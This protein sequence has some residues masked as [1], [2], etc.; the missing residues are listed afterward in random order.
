[1]KFF[2]QCIWGRIL[3][4]RQRLT[5]IEVMQDQDCSPQ[6][7]WRW[8]TEHGRPCCSLRHTALN[9]WKRWQTLRRISRKS[10]ASGLM[11]MVSRPAHSSLA[12]NWRIECII[13]TDAT[14]EPMHPTDI[15]IK[16]WVTIFQ[17]RQTTMQGATPFHQTCGP[18]SLV[19]LEIIHLNIINLSTFAFVRL[20][21]SW[22]FQ[23]FW[24]ACL[25][26]FPDKY[27]VLGSYLN[28]FQEEPWSVYS[29]FL[30]IIVVKKS[31]AYQK[32]S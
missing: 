6:D 21:V 13:H 14:K 27:C 7:T 17:T 23:P 18:P 1:M 31:F 5:N 19:V 3:H 11:I 9:H 2:F 16:D 10:T 28:L 24:Y 12:T 20:Q 25:S 4:I 15:D 26:E 30:L 32:L 8:N 29:N 22:R